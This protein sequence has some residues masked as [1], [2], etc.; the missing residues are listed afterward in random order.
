MAYHFSRNLIKKHLV[1]YMEDTSLWLDA[2]LQ[3]TLPEV[4]SL[5]GLYKF[6]ATKDAIKFYDVVA[7]KQ[8][9][10]LIKQA[11]LD[12]NPDPKL[13]TLIFMSLIVLLVIA[14]VKILLRICRRCC[15]S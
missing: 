15:S 5:L 8:V 13:A 1:T 2:K 12:Y 11:G 10:Q 6:Y 9:D 7:R 3:H 4:V 14:V